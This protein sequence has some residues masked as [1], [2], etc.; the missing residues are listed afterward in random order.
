MSIKVLM[1]PRNHEYIRLLKVHLE[2]HGIKIRLLKPFH[3]SAPLNFLKIIYSRLMGYRIVHVHWLY[4][5]PLG[6]MMKGFV[7]FCKVLGIRIIWELHNILPHDKRKSDLLHSKWFYENVDHVIF[8]SKEDIQRVKD[9][10]STHVVHDEDVIPHGNF[11]GSYPNSISKL[12][13][14]E[15]LE[16]PTCHR[17]ILCFGFIRRNR[18]YEYLVEAV[19]DMKETTVLVAG[20]VLEKEVYRQLLLWQEQLPNLRVEGKW[21]ADEDLQLYFNASDIVVLPYTD[22]TTSGVI[23]LAYSFS[24][25]VVSTRIG[26]IVDVVNEQTGIL[27]PPRDSGSLKRAIEKLFESDY[28]EMGRLANEYSEKTLGWDPIALK[29]RKIYEK[30]L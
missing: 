25:P 14:R 16:I 5:F 29:M 11:N 15:L 20:T 7:L 21:I 9:I 13:A 30:V 12:K 27:V 19:R 10:Y 3:Y 24:R 4:I 8:H 6:I 26:G 17:M 28:V 1:V 18:G 22:I 23:P 2:L